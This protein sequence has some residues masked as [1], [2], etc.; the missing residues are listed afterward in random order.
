M[1]KRV[2]RGAALFQN[3]EKFRSLYAVRS[4]FFKTELTSSDGRAQITG[5]QVPGE[6]LG[7]DG[8]ASE[9]HSVDAIALEDSEVC[10]LPFGDLER[11]ARDFQPLQHQLHRVMSREIVRDNGV[12]MLLGSMKAEE[13]VAA[14]LLNLSERYRTLGY[15]DTE[16]VLRMTRAE[17]GS[18]LG[19]KLETASRAV[20]KLQDMGIIS[21]NGKSVTITDKPGITRFI[22]GS[23]SS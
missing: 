5:F 20:S 19:L 7:L 10:V 15:S 1:R 8:L 18:Y 2:K 23:K 6:L 9:L 3:G 11:I 22:N 21:V 4:G 17:M 16:F 12:M 14:F 13:R